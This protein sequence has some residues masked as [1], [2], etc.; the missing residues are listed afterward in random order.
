MCSFWNNVITLETY[1]LFSVLQYN[2]LNIKLTIII[3]H[4]LWYS[5]ISQSIN[6]MFIVFILEWIN[7]FINVNAQNEKIEYIPEFK[8]SVINGNYVFRVK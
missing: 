6:I 8:S 1:W 7:Y 4:L 3:D 5:L 2:V